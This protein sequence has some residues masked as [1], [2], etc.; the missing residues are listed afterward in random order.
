MPDGARQ[1]LIELLVRIPIF[2][3]LVPDE[4]RRLMTICKQASYAEGETIYA[5]GTPGAQLLILL[6]GTVS[7]QMPDGSEI[8]QIK[9]V[10]TVGE[11]EIASAQPRVA[12]VLALT[13]VSGLVVGRADLENLVNT[14]P[15]LGI[16]ILKNIIGTLARKLAAADQQLTERNSHASHSG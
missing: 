10:D 4:C 6:K 13:D 16:K 7:I 9:P 5:A 12:N 8:I 15:F 2:D 14:E 3:G 11:M 1:N